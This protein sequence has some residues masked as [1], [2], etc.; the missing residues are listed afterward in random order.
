MT[1][2]IED[3]YRTTA[4]LLRMARKDLDPV[5]VFAAGTRIEDTQEAI[6]IFKGNTKI[7]QVTVLRFG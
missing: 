3:Q 7:R 1:N 6:L 4:Q 5:S 2:P